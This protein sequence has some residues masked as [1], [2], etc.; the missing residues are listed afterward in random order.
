MQWHLDLKTFNH[1]TKKTKKIACWQ[2]EEYTEE[3][4]EGKQGK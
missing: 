4:T 3:K 2:C 1:M